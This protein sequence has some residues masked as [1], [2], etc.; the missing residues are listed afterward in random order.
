MPNIRSYKK[1]IRE[2]KSGDIFYMNAIGVSLNMI[3]YTKELIKGGKIT[4]VR[5]ELEKMV[6]PQYIN[7]FLNGEKIAPQMEYRVI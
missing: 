4:P 3:E 2:A 7:D 6:N 5:E 1:L